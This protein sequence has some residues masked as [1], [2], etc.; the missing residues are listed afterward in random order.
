[1]LLAVS[2]TNLGYDEDEWKAHGSAPDRPEGPPDNLV[3]VVENYLEGKPDSS[4]FFFTQT[5]CIVIMIGVS[6]LEIRHIFLWW[7]LTK[8]KSKVGV[9]QCDRSYN[10]ILDARYHQCGSDPS[11]D[12]CQAEFDKLNDEEKKNYKRIPIDRIIPSLLTVVRSRWFS[13]PVA[14]GQYIVIPV[15]TT[16]VSVL[17]ILES[18]NVLDCIKDTVVSDIY[19]KTK[20]CMHARVVALSFSTSSRDHR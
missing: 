12:L 2:A 17:L 16:E 10:I 5:I 7:H 6:I 18:A 3:L 19:I 8:T 20:G 11:Y 1:M 15:L 14:V 4:L 13:M 9:F